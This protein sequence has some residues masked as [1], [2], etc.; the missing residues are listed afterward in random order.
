MNMLELTPIDTLTATEK[1]HREWVH[2][3]EWHLSLVPQLLDVI[4]METLPHIRATQLD[5]PR[6]TGGGHIDNMTILDHLDTT[7][8][9]RVVSRD[10]TAA[11]DAQTLWTWITGYTSAVTAWINHTIPVPYA[12]ILPPATEPRVDRDPLL[13]RSLA[14][15]TIGWLIDHAH[16]IEPIRELDEHRDAMFTLI[17]HLRGKYGVHNH[18]RRPR[19]RRCLTCGN[20]TVILDWA[21]ANNGSPKPVRVAKCRTCG[22]TNHGATT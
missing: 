13:A 21:T 8:D 6:I 19:P 16:L 10:N 12:P 22:E 15:T 20:R 4:I 14:L 1:A 17:R 2:A 3:F 5:K 11:A 18:P 7:P 9:R